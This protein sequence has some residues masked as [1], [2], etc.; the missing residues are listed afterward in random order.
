MFYIFCQ[1]LSKDSKD[2][3]VHWGPSEKWPLKWKNHTEWMKLWHD[4][5]TSNRHVLYQVSLKSVKEFKQ[6]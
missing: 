3:K 2:M 4:N 1:N 5:S 6:I